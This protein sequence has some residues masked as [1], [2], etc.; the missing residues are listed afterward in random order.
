AYWI[1][2][3]LFMLVSL[4]TAGTAQRSNGRTHGLAGRRHP[5]Y[6]YGPSLGFGN[7]QQAPVGAAIGDVGRHPAL[8]R[9]YLGAGA[10]RVVEQPYRA[11]AH[12]GHGYPAQFIE[13]N[14]VRPGAARHLDPVADTAQGPIAAQWNAP[15][16]I[17]AG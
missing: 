15:D 3:L 9:P 2:V 1:M 11:H 4:L 13:R 5:R 8:R 6:E 17:G 7:E 14:S 10:A 16:C 12:V